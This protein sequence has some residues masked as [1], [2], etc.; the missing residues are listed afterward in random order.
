MWV[1]IN[2]ADPVFMVGKIKVSKTEYFLQK[3]YE[4]T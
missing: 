3:L 1:V 4:L 2:L